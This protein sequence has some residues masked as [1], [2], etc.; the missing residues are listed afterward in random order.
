[1]YSC[2]KSPQ[3]L[4]FLRTAIF[5]RQ[6]PQCYFIRRCCLLEQLVFD[7]Q[8]R[9]HSYTFYLSFCKFLDSNFPVCTEWCTTQKMIPLNTMNKNFAKKS[10]FRVALNR[11]IYRNMWKFSFWGVW[12]SKS[13]ESAKELTFYYLL[14][15]IAIYSPSNENKHASEMR[16]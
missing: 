8:P 3:S 2:W 6:F 11:I 10:I 16:N 9:F 15:L 13:T 12:I 14:F 7:W 1:M 4:Y 5:S